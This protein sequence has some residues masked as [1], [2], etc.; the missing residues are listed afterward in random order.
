MIILC[1]ANQPCN[2]FFFSFPLAKVSNFIQMSK[3]GVQGPSTPKNNSVLWSQGKVEYNNRKLSSSL[4]VVVVLEYTAVAAA[5][6]LPWNGITHDVV[7][8]LSSCHS[9]T[10]F[11][12]QRGRIADVRFFFSP[13]PLG[14]SVAESSE[15]SLRNYALYTC[16]LTKR[17][18]HKALTHFEIFRVLLCTISKRKLPRRG[19]LSPAAAVWNGSVVGCPL[20][21]KHGRSVRLLNMQPPPPTSAELMAGTALSV[22]LLLSLAI[23]IFE[24]AAAIKRTMAPRRQST[25]SPSDKNN[26]SSGGEGVVVQPP[27]ARCKKCS[28][29]E[30][31]WMRHLRQRIGDSPSQRQTTEMSP[32]QVSV[33]FGD[34][35]AM[36]EVLLDP[37][38]HHA[39]SSFHDRPTVD[40]FWTSPS[41]LS[42]LNQMGPARFGSRPIRRISTPDNNFLHPVSHRNGRINSPRRSY[43]GSTPYTALPLTPGVMRLCG[44]LS[45]ISEASSAAMDGDSMDYSAGTSSLPR[46][47]LTVDHSAAASQSTAVES[48]L[49]R[50]RL[51]RHRWFVLLYN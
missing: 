13:S 43:A 2:S 14:E 48:R 30:F 36:A 10:F 9:F 39:S 31:T 25:P 42:Q 27:P 15:R 40:S 37:E 8:T 38:L 35:S 33:S 4:S 29:S 6:A 45:D 32:P 26:N 41:P 22:V 21:E 5:I 12:R 49:K 47:F 51:I 11:I 28:L 46:T 34:S 3:Q 7:V 1:P 50:I 20:H 24:A 17:F 16:A 19:S 18:T 23:A 44:S